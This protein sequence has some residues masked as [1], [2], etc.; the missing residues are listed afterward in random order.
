MIA[1]HRT[2]VSV[3]ECIPR[4]GLSIKKKL[5]WFATRALYISL[6]SAHPV[7]LQ[8][9]QRRLRRNAGGGVL[10]GPV[11]VLSIRVSVFFMSHV[12]LIVG[13]VS[14]GAAPGID[15]AELPLEGRVASSSTSSGVSSTD[16]ARKGSRIDL[17]RQT[18]AAGVRKR[19][20]SATWY[21]AVSRCELDRI[22]VLDP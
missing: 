9:M 11:P 15:L 13:V 8:I 2:K 18:S 14:L 7:Q 20:G 10:S 17:L 6:L 19:A 16:I 1:N 5:I 22:D 21:A 4:P 3:V 12:A